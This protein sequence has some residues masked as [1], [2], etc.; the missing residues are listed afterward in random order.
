MK[1]RLPNQPT[2]D[3]LDKVMQEYVDQV[4][5]YWCIGDNEWNGMRDS[6]KLYWAYEFG[7]ALREKGDK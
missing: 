3:Q 7:N 4:K 1:Q 2:P 5:G 6:E